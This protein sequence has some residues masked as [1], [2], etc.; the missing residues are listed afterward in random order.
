LPHRVLWALKS[1]NR[2][3]GW[4][5]CT[6]DCRSFVFQ[7]L[8]GG[9]YIE[10]RVKGLVEMMRTATTCKLEVIAIGEVYYCVRGR[11]HP[12][13]LTISTYGSRMR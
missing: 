11:P 6:T 4:G 8:Y 3:I 1:P 9:R 13:R 7:L 5:S 10:Q 2:S 12:I